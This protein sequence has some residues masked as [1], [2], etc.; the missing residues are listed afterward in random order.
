MKGPS[1]RPRLLAVNPAGG[2]PE[3]PERWSAQRKME[4][5]LRLLRGRAA[6][7]RLAREPG[8]RA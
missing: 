2:G 6:G 3:L 7:C 5:V 4:L 8:A 1:G